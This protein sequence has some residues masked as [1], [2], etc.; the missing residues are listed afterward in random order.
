MRTDKAVSVD[1]RT[2]WEQF[3]GELHSFLLSR[4]G[5]E[6]AAQDLLQSAFLRAHRS[7][8]AG[9]IPEHPRAWLYQIV[10]NL[11]I[12]SRRQAQRQRDLAVAVAS[13]PV[14]EATTAADEQDA[15]AVVARAL[16]IFIEALEPVYR[17]ALKMTELEGLTQSEAATRAGVSLSGMKS[18]VQRGRKQVFDS[19]Q[20][21]CE[22]RLDSRG[23]MIACTSRSHAEECC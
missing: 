23:R 5:S 19:L 2:L 22:F 10:R 16:P 18:R 17:D 21:C 6:E 7:L 12:D 15:F 1:T 9:D 4:V 11:I 14:P 13:E 8:G 20:R 3:H